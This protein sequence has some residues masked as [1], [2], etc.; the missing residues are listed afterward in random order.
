MVCFLKKAYFG[1]IVESELEGNKNESREM[2][3]NIT[4]ER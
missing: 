4:M 3:W 1:G 2:N